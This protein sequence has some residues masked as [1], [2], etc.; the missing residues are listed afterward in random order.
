MLIKHTKIILEGKSDDE[1]DYPMDKSYAIGD[2]IDIVTDDSHEDCEVMDKV[3]EC[4][5]EGNDKIINVIYRLKALA[6]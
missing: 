5:N 6:G 2:R 3:I 4:S 1:L